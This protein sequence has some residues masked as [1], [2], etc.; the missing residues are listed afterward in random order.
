MAKVKVRIPAPLQ[1]I[2][3]DKQE[4]IAEAKNIKE[5]ILDLEKQLKAGRFGVLLIS[6]L[7]MRIFVS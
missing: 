5:L 3:Q 6:M 1:K 4:V 7:M 2:T